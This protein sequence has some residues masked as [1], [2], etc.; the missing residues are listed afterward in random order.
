MRF[1]LLIFAAGYEERKEVECNLQVALNLKGYGDIIR[2][3]LK[4]MN[5]KPDLLLNYGKLGLR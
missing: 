1:L 3:L 4:I 5:H 2:F